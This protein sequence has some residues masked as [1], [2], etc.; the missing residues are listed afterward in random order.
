MISDAKLRAHLLSALHGLRNS[1]TGWVP[2]S[3]MNFGGLEPVAP[4]R[5]RTVCEQLAAAGLV[6]FKPAP[7]EL[8]RGLIGMSKI[9]G[10]G[11]DVVEGLAASSIALEF[12]QAGTPPATAPSAVPNRTVDVSSPGAR[13]SVAT[14][15]EAKSEMLILKPTIWGMGIDLKEA[16]RRT[17]RRWSRRNA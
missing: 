2:V 7:G 3:D 14:T 15:A 5:I 17:L 1:N 4:G 8:D 12:P 13:P 10:H 6:A 16:Y 11:S 9:S